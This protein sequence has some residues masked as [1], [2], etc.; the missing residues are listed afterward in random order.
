MLRVGRGILCRPPGAPA[1]EP[2]TGATSEETPQARPVR[3][4]PPSS[5]HT[6]LAAVMREKPAT[7]GA[8]QSMRLSLR[9]ARSTSQPPSTPPAAAPRVKTAWAGAIA[10]SG[11]ALVRTR[12]ASGG[13]VR[14]AGRAGKGALDKGSRLTPNQEA[15]LSSR[16]GA[17]AAERRRLGMAGEL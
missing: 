17:G 4:R 9:P 5:I 6:S 11:A 13:G 14:A 12:A 1:R 15:V 2:L 8:V 7:K 3:R 16:R 10:S